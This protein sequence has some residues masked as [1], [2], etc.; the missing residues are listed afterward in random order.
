TPLD[1]RHS[2]AGGPARLSASLT[3]DLISASQIIAAEAGGLPVGGSA[4]EPGAATA[5][6]FERPGEGPGDPVGGGV[7]PQPASRT[8]SAR[9]LAGQSKRVT[10][11]MPPV[12]EPRHGAIYC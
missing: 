5:P 10:V 11:R 1:Q 2:V 4:F 9:K 8:R 3:F 7:A 12:G 6:T